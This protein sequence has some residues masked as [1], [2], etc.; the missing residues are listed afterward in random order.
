MRDMT[1]PLLD[2]DH[3]GHPDIVR[4][5]ASDRDRNE[6]VPCAVANISQSHDR[7][8]FKSLGEYP[9]YEQIRYRRLCSDAKPTPAIRRTPCNTDEGVNEIADIEPRAPRRVSISVA[10]HTHRI[11]KG[12]RPERGWN[13]LVELLV[14]SKEALRNHSRNIDARLSADD[15]LARLTDG[16][17]TTRTESNR[18]IIN[19]IINLKRSDFIGRD[20]NDPSP[21]TLGVSECVRHHGDTVRQRLRWVLKRS[22]RIG[23]SSKRENDIH[24]SGYTKPIP[25]IVADD[26]DLRSQLVEWAVHIAH[27]SDDIVAFFQQTMYEVPANKSASPGD[28]SSHARRLP[29]RTTC[30]PSRS[31]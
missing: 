26:L 30:S 29:G 15:F 23:R 28:K 11:P 19:L 14:L 8:L 24:R 10:L 3:R 4:D 9:R 12:Q 22:T 13:E 17:W 21:D 1:Q 31:G 18:S 25:E 16:I 20:M 2:T 5:I 6:F 27:N 7:I